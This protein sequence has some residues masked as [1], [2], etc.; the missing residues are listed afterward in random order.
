[1]IMKKQV[2]AFHAVYT[3]R[4]SY[5]IL[6]MAPNTLLCKIIYR[7]VCRGVQKHISVNAGLKRR[8]FNLHR[9]LQTRFCY[10]L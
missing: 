10:I 6:R 4:L 5:V 7:Y 3:V 1:M 9:M 8:I 2:A